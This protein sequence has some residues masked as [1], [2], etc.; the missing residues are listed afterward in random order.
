M[1]ALEVFLALVAFAAVVAVV[2]ERVR[3][4]APSLLVVAG[5]LVGLARSSFSV[6]IPPEFVSVVV[7]PPLLYAAA[8]DVSMREF[9]AV[10][11]PV[12]VLAIGLVAFSAIVVALTVHGLAPQ[13]TLPVAF[14]LG[15]IVAS[16]D[17]VAVSALARRLRLPP[18]LLALVQGES[19]LNDATSLVLFSVAVGIVASG[20]T[21]SSTNVIG[22]FI[23]L[24]GGGALVGFAMGWVVERLRRRTRDAV[25]HTVIALLTPYVVF[26]LAE[27]IHASG[28]TA[29]VVFGLSLSRRGDLE[30]RG[31]V[32]LQV[33]HFYAVIIFL[34]ESLAFA[35]IGLELPT[36]VRR[37][38]PTDRES[39]WVAVA[40]TAA[41][42]LTRVV[43]IFPM[44]A[45]RRI[46]GV[47]ERVAGSVAPWR[48]LVVL[49]W[50]G[51]RGVVPLAAALSIP[52]LRDDGTPFP[53]RDLILALA[54]SCII[55]TLLI[56]GLTLEPLVRRLN[57][58]TDKVTLERERASAEQAAANA[59][60]AS[61]DDLEGDEIPDKVIDK[62]RLEWQSRAR[63]ARRLVDDF[64]TD[65]SGG[66]S[67]SPAT[68]DA[69]Y[70][71]V[72][73]ALLALESEQLAAMRED[74]RISESVRREIQRSLDL[75]EAALSDNEK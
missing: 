29:V 67:H 18:R 55:L 11:R 60:L 19:L 58:R 31:P 25:L 4:P 22:Q 50:V 34:L 68:S 72:R 17:P 53:E 32:R 7:L 71:S 52:V 8:T 1:Y 12:F 13:V 10:L 63:R 20:T 48:V 36:L 41:V 15:A 69:A 59:A 62:L 75:E 3:I 45:I 23:W 16:T 24:G 43:W 61:I 44:G 26:V 33:A 66:E 30:L 74:G 35:L 64:D 56:Q 51:T 49:S 27:A 37:L 9:R 73:L 14:V 6:D 46:V 2:A 54:I 38:S 39:L 47:R 57:V 28:V 21:V 5:L 65:N 40:V 42:M 70:R